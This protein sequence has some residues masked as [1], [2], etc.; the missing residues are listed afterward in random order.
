MMANVSDVRMKVVPDLTQIKI[1]E[2]LQ[3][4]IN[5]LYEM[6]LAMNDGESVLLPESDYYY[7]QI[8]NENEFLGPFLSYRVAAYIG[9]K[10]YGVGAFLIVR[11]TSPDLGHFDMIYDI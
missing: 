2:N 8:K 4:Q 5:L 3:A 9:R 6:I 1:N 10:M 7:L 11:E